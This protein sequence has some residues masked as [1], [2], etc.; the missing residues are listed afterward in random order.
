MTNFFL[1]AGWEVHVADYRSHWFSI[2]PLKTRPEYT[3]T[4]GQWEMCVIAK[5]N[6]LE[7]VN[8]VHKHLF[9]SL[10]NKNSIYGG[11]FSK[12]LQFLLFYDYREG[13]RCG[14]TCSRWTCPSR[15]H[16]WDIS[17]RKPKRYELRV[18]I[19]NTDDVVLEDDSLLTGEK[20]SDIYVKGWVGWGAAKYPKCSK[21]RLSWINVCQRNV[22][23]NLYGS[24]FI[25]E[26][27]KK[28]I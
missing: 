16:P 21:P 10:L 24:H 15:A 17:P 6:R 27:F 28:F 22:E 2:N 1:K 3:R 23:T 11:F 9:F 4:G 18:I 8:P 12:I 25:T 19:W 20:M 14:W 7:Q 13:L 26:L 5:S